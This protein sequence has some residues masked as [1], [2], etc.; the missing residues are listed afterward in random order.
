MSPFP[1]YI[2]TDIYYPPN[3]K[4]APNFHAQLRYRQIPTCKHERGRAQRGRNLLTV[5]CMIKIGDFQLEHESTGRE[6]I[7]TDQG[8]HPWSMNQFTTYSNFNTI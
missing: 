6:Y 2:H 8:K 3:K 1:Y 4:G 7:K 5:F